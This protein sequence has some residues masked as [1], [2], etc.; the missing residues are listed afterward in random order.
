MEGGAW[1]E[2]AVP[3]ELTFKLTLINKEPIME[4]TRGTAF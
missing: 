3:K 1:L 4:Q 2:E